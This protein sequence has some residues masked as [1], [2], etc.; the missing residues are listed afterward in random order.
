MLGLAGI[1]AGDELFERGHSVAV[2]ISEPL[3]AREIWLRMQ[4]ADPVEVGLAQGSIEPKGAAG[5]NVLDVARRYRRCGPS[6]GS[7]AEI[8]EA[9]RDS[10]HQVKRQLR[11]VRRPRPSHKPL[12][13]WRWCRAEETDLLGV[14]HAAPV[15]F[16]PRFDD[17][18]RPGVTDD[19]GGAAEGEALC[20][21]RVTGE[22]VHL[23]VVHEGHQGYRGRVISHVHIFLPDR[24]SA[25]SAAVVT[26]HQPARGLCARL[27]MDH[28]A[29]FTTP[30][31][32][33]GDGN[34]DAGGG[35]PCPSVVRVLGPAMR[36]LFPC[37]APA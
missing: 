4:R 31:L 14:P 11:V 1:P 28:Q 17:D 10:G 33:Q 29:V 21:R 15:K 27:D 9:L 12:L 5:E 16:V 36:D 8:H 32:A 30:F 13:D 26:G 7:G 35:W 23:H 22:R 19:D 6:H 3:Q 20:G 34:V 37:R 25:S 2:H 24:I 18:H